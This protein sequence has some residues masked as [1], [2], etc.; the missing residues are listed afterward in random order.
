MKLNPF[1]WRKRFWESKFWDGFRQEIPDPTLWEAIKGVML[2]AAVLFFEEFVGH[3]FF[4]LKVVVVF[5]AIR[6]IAIVS[7][8]IVW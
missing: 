8:L 7:G 6:K 1:Y 4:W 3:T 5:L 2:M